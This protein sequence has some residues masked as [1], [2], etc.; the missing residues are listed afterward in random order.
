LPCAPTGRRTHTGRGR[1]PERAR[2]GGGDR[3][4]VGHAVLDAAA[5]RLRAEALHPEP[6]DAVG[7]RAERARGDR[8]SWAGPGRASVI[9]PGDPTK[10]E[11]RR[12]RLMIGT[13]FAGFCV[14]CP[15]LYL[16]G[17]VPLLD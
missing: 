15:L 1:G 6:R 16:V 3:V 2:A 10:E 17:G 8:D 14:V 9:A 13:G 7:G 5:G 12:S 11:A 4:R